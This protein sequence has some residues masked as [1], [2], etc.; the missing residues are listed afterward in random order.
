MHRQDIAAALTSANGSG[1]EIPDFE[2]D[3][4]AIAAYE[5]AKIRYER[6]EAQDAEAKARAAFNKKRDVIRA[7]IAVAASLLEEKQSRAKKALENFARHYPNRMDKNR[8]I[9][10]GFWENLTSL[11]R[12]RRMYWR[13]INATEDARQAQTLR[14]RKEH[15]EEELEQQLK[16]SLYLQE[17]SIKKRL[18]S[19][20]GIA[21]FHARPGIAV[22]WKR[23]EE[24]NA[25]RA[26]YAA[27]LEKGDVSP[28]EQRDREFAERK[29]TQLEAPFA[30]A[31][32]IRVSRYGDFTYYILRDLE[33][34]L[35]RLSYDPRLEPL[36]DTV[37][38]VYRLADSYEAKQSRA[39]DGRPLSGLDH[40]QLI[41]KDE[42]LARS[43]YRKQRN[44]LRAPRTDIPPITPANDQESTLLDLLASLARTVV[45]AAGHAMG[46]LTPIPP[47]LDAVRSPQAQ[48]PA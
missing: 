28:Q 44:A 47:P 23:V 32:I 8:P 2:R 36:L 25:E 38:E 24:I 18:E 13:C 19:P 48:P 20:E 11:G 39:Q 7:E 37:F 6:R 42:E 16:R 33:K 40:Y 41:L 10:P 26:A 9:K 35:Y 29:I 27:R 45:P 15:D 30:G 3:A 31:S 5:D 17:E 4:Q 22:L 21:Q 46:Q 43:E 14:R 34:R 12:A 1:P